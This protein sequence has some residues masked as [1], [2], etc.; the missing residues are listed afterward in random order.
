MSTPIRRRP[1]LPPS[2]LDSPDSF[3][4]ADSAYLKTVLTMSKTNLDA[5]I[6]AAEEK[7][8]QILQDIFDPTPGLITKNY[9]LK[10]IKVVIKMKMRQILN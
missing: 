3:N 2:L 9:L 10:L 8:K 7:N 5:T 6:E 4:E 1:P